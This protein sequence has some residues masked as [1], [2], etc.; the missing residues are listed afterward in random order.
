MTDDVKLYQLKAGF[1]K[2]HNLLIYFVARPLIETE[3]ALYLYGHGTTDT[4]RMGVCC[5]CGRTLTHPVSVELGIGPEC[6][7]HFHNWDLIGGYTKENIERLKGALVEIVVDS[8]VPKSQIV[9]AFDTLETVVV[10]TDHPK[11]KPKPIIPDLCTYSELVLPPTPKRA[12]ISRNQQGDDIIRI[13]FKYDMDIIEKIRT[14]PGRKY[15]TED[16][17][18]SAPLLEKTVK[19]LVEWGFTLDDSLQGYNEHVNRVTKELVVDGILGLKGKL[20][21]FQAE[22]VAFIEHHGGRALIA[23]EMGLGKTVQSLAWLQ[24]HPELRP[25]LIVCPASLKLNW[26]REAEMWMPHPD[27]RVISGSQPYQIDNEILIINYDIMPKWVEQM[28]KIAPKVLIMDEAHFIKSNKAQRTKALKEVGKGIRHVLAL[29]GTPIVN[30]PIEMFNALRMIDPE[31]FHDP[32]HYARRYCNAH[33]G[34]FGWDFSGASFTEELHQLLTGSLMIRRLKKD[35]L[36]DLPPKLYSYVP[37]ELENAQTY[38]EAEADFIAFVRETKGNEAARRASR[39]VAFAKVE[40]LKQLAVHGKLAQAIEWID[41]FLEIDGKLVIFAFHTE[42]INILH[43]HFGALSVKYDG[44]MSDVQKETAKEAFQTNPEIR[45]FIGN[46]KAAGLGLTLTAASN[47]GF[48]ELPWTPGDLDQCTD[49]LHRIGQRDSVMVHYLLAANTIEERIAKLI[50]SKRGVIDSI[51]DGKITD[52]ES[53]LSILM[54][55]YET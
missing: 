19:Q 25:A 43:E 41:N 26:L 7:Q 32:W 16:K 36:K 28:K 55:D 35:V 45:L 22:G 15:H 53:M 48:L 14:L 10:P 54:K 50:D 40:G 30:R 2:H 37:I 29:T 9:N 11:I 49:R 23:D 39:A 18:W 4:V 42:I 1:A 34:R 44:S 33:K 24:L 51:I 17:C 21:P 52:T 38:Y 12:S 8:W 13:D 31:Q 47:V 5:K 3:R 20:F 6:G 27:A 46:L